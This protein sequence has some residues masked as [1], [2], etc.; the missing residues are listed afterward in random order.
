MH[1]P[2]HPFLSALRRF[3]ENCG[4]INSTPAPYLG[5]LETIPWASATYLGERHQFDLILSAQD[6]A[7]IDATIHQLQNA[8]FPVTGHVLVD[9]HLESSEPDVRDCKRQRLHFAALTLNAREGA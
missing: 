9:I 7:A 4:A 8:N 6:N 2:H 1:P 3:V 5:F